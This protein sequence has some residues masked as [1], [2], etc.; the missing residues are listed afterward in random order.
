MGVETERKFLLKN[1]DWKEEIT[2][3]PR[4]LTQGYFLRAQGGP[5]MR[6]RIADD[7]GFITIKG[8]AKGEENISR[9]EFE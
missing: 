2:S 8:R 7:Q 1:H 9:S 4:T 6:V 3:L 5:T